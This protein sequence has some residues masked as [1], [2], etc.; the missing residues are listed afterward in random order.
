[1]TKRASVCNFGN[2]SVAM[3]DYIHG[4]YDYIHGNTAYLQAFKYDSSVISTV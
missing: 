1:M 4:A 3:N 2:T